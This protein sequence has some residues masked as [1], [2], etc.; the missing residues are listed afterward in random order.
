MPFVD[1]LKNIERSSKVLEDAFGLHVVEGDLLMSDVEGSGGSLRNNI[2]Q[3]LGEGEWDGVQGAWFRGLN[4]PET[5]FRFHPGKISSGDNDPVQGVDTYF[6]SAVPYSATVWI[7]FKTPAGVGESDNKKTPPSGFA[8]IFR[9]LKCNNYDISGNITGYGYTSNPARVAAHLLLKRGNIS[10]LRIDWASW[11]SW[12]DYC[13]ELKLWDYAANHAT[14]PGIGLYG[15]YYNVTPANIPPQPW[16]QGTTPPP[17]F[18][19][20]TLVFNRVDAVIDT[21]LTNGS[22]GIGVNSEWFLVRWEGKIKPQFSGNYTFYC[23]HDNGARLWVN[24][25]QIFN[26]WNQTGGNSSGTISLTAETLADI[27]LEFFEGWGLSKIKLEW[28]H[29][30]QPRQVLPT[31]RL[32]PKPH[33]KKRYEAHVAF[34]NPTNLDDAIRTVL[35]NTNSIMQDDGEKLRFFCLEQLTAPTFVFNEE[36]IIDGT[37]KFYRRDRRDLRNRWQADFRDLDSQYLEK[38]YPPVIIEVAELQETQGR[39]IDGA[40]VELQNTTRYQAEKVLLETV[41][42]EVL[43]DLFCEFDGNADSF[44][45]LP[46]DLVS[47][48]H[49]VPNWTAKTF[50]CISA[51]DKSS[52]ETADE[53]AFILQERE[54]FTEPPDPPPAPTFDE[55]TI[56][57]M[58]ALEI[59]NDATVF[60]SG[61]AQER[62]GAQLWSAVDALVIALKTANLWQKFYAIYLFVGGTAAR[63]KFNLK[64]PADTNAAFR[65]AFAGT[66]THN[67]LGSQG[68]GT[69]GYADTF[70]NPVTNFTAS[71]GSIWIYS[72]SNTNSLIDVGVNVTTFTGIICKHDNGF[73]YLSYGTGYAATSGLRGDGRFTVVRNNSTDTR[74]YRFGT[75]VFANAHTPILDNTSFYLG[76]GNAGVANAYSGKQYCELMFGQGFSATE[77]AQVNTIFDVFQISLNRQV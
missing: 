26:T 34:T 17:E 38:A 12:R 66:W 43:N 31:E 64:N 51:I 39:V 32:Y 55:A 67:H 36:N 60:Y 20:A 69:S 73:A 46:G 57:Y 53:R 23:E 18:N 22:P 61:T 72:R 40:T 45:V 42:R 2:A 49:N 62:T 59:A 11:V 27:R 4:I 76:A 54:P 25:I 5:D 16:N 14:K 6:D 77:V 58:N 63:H 37:F 21:D 9:C 3:V 75:E 7:G 28:E 48:A 70:F 33:Y 29:A 71:S 52:E 1:H 68:N 74:G 30:N 15:Q 10:P 41:K 19:Q 35:N 50:I 47:V 24:G 56:A 8:G 13:D 65:L 44:P